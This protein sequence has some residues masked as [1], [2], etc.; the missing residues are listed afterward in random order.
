MY[1]LRRSIAASDA[2]MAEALT[3]VLAVEIDGI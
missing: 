3:N 2:E 1:D